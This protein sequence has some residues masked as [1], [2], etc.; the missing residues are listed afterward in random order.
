MAIRRKDVM[1]CTSCINNDLCFLCLAGFL[2]TGGTGE[3]GAGACG[4]DGDGERILWRRS[5]RMSSRMRMQARSINGQSSVCPS[6]KTAETVRETTSNVTST[7]IS[8]SQVDM[9]SAC[10]E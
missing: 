5:S 2:N 4:A 10:M 6:V 1:Y 7:R 9:S 3:G 8:V